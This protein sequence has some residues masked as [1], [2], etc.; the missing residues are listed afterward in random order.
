MYQ[1][2]WAD[3]GDIGWMRGAPEKLRYSSG[4][5]IGVHSAPNRLPVPEIGRKLER[6]GPVRWLVRGGK[7]VNVVEKV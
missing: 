4:P 6:H 3:V 1:A 5:V 7:K 2:R